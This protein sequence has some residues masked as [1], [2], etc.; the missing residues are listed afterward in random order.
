MAKYTKEVL[1]EAV[2]NATSIMGVLRYL[3]LR[4]AGGTHSHISRKIKM[5]GICPKHFTGQ[6]HNK[7]KIPQNRKTAEEILVDSG[8]KRQ[9]P[10]LLRRAL[11]ESGILYECSHCGINSWCGEKIV[12]HVDHI[13]GNFSN[14]VLSNLRFLCP[15]CHS[16]KPTYSRKKR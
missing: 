13:D 5:F 6:S 16:Q 2:S 14:N 7:G 12:L 1:Q 9:K 4:E 8:N 15:N 11:T 10:R 3:G